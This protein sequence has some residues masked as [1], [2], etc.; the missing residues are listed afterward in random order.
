MAQEF[1]IVASERKLK[2]AAE[3]CNPKVENGKSEFHLAWRLCY[4]WMTGG[5]QTK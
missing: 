4:E 2:E 1:D 5:G 3:K